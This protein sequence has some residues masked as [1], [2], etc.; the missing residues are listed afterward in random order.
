[1]NESAIAQLVSLVIGKLGATPVLIFLLVLFIAPWVAVI[2]IV[3]GLDKRMTKVF[4]RQDKRFEEVVNMYENNVGLVHGYEKITNNL[5]DL[6]ILVTSTMQTLIE[7]IKHNFF[8]PL[9]RQ[10]TKG[11]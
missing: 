9:N 1:M 4:D 10:N 5:Q 11:G 3:R 8:C 7:H 2:A 6:V